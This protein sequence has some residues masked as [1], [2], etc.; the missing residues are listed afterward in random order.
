MAGKRELQAPVTAGAGMAC[1]AGNNARLARTAS[2]SGLAPPTLQTKKK[3]VVV[4]LK[5]NGPMMH[6]YYSFSARSMFP[7]SS[8]MVWLIQ[9]Q[10]ERSDK[11]S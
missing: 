2:T 5:K 7:D 10:A 1:S 9:E 8:C 4:A 3:C 6:K 11:T